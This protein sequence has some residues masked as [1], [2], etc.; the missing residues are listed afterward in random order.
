MEI[1]KE[2]TISEILDIDMQIAEILMEHGMHCVGCPAHAHETLEEACG[3]HD[4]DVE[5]LIA[6]INERLK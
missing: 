3:I 6:K 4:I 1:S 2:M 5:A